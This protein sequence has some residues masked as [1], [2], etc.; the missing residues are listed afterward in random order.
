MKKITIVS[1]IAIFILSGKLFAQDEKNPWAIGVGINMVDVSGYGISKPFDQLKDYVGLSDLNALPVLSR[2]YVAKYLNKGF[3]VDIAGAINSIDEIPS[4]DVSEKNYYSLDLGLRYD[5]NEWFGQTGWFDPYAK[6]S[7]GGAWVEDDS[8]ITLSPGLGFNTWFNDK[9]GL[10]FESAYKASSLFDADGAGSAQYIGAYHFQ[11]SVSLVIKFGA[12]DTD[13]DGIVDKDDLCPNIVGKKELQGCPDMDG[14][15]I[16]DKDDACP[17]Y[18][19]TAA[20]NGCPDADGDGVIDSKDKCP[21]QAG[22]LGGC[23]DAD[24]D[25]FADD[26]DKC[27][28]LAGKFNGC[29]DSDND[30]LADNVDKCPNVKGPKYNNGCPIKKLTEEAKKQLGTYAKTIQFN[31]GKANFKAG[32]TT[33]LDAIAEVMKEFKNIKFDVEGHSD[34]SGNEAKNLKLSQ[35]RAQAVVDYLGTHGIDSKRLHAVGYGIT[36]PIASN[37]TAAGRAINRRVVLTAIESE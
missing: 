19:G 30:G 23:P 7:V 16:A 15:G 29:P 25:G 28:N 21:N 37:K 12:K 26:K 5:L 22:K 34:S 31:S 9:V 13:S 4:G 32:V 36:K 27:P 14:D 11:H 3:T 2:L 20:T 18:A 10:N 8:A 33:T 17:E 24:G 1:F 35:D 6:F